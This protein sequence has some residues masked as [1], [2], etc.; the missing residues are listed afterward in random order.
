M[1]ANYE[2]TFTVSLT[3]YKYNE[4]THLMLGP[5]VFA[6]MQEPSISSQACLSHRDNVGMSEHP[7]RALASKCF[8][9]VYEV[10]IEGHLVGRTF[11][12]VPHP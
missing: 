10:F 6:Y 7:L 5:I 12:T 4:G 3:R 11:Y 9:T 2:V 8:V 1:Q